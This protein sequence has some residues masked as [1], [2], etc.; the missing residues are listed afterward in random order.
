MKVFISD[1]TVCEEIDQYRRTWKFECGC[2]ASGV[3]AGI[4]GASSGIRLH[5]CENHIPA[6]LEDP[7]ILEFL[8]EDELI[9]WMEEVSGEELEFEFDSI[10]LQTE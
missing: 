2:E 5:P 8:W 9:E 6:D 4:S 7:P 10:F 1:E 3:L